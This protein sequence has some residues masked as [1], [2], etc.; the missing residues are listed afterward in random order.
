MKDAEAD[1]VIA[2]ATPADLLRLYQ[3]AQ[4]VVGVAFMPDAMDEASKKKTI[5]EQNLAD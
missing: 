5:A 2:A 3:I 4:A 1:K